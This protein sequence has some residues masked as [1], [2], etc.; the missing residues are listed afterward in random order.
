MCCFFI[1]IILFLVSFFFM[2]ATIFTNTLNTCCS[3]HSRFQASSEPKTKKR[4]S[5]NYVDICTTL[6]LWNCL[7]CQNAETDGSSGSNNIDKHV[8][9]PG[10]WAKIGKWKCVCW[11]IPLENFLSMLLHMHSCVQRA[12]SQMTFT[13]KR[14]IEELAW[15][16]QDFIRFSAGCQH[17]ELSGAEWCSKAVREYD[18]ALQGWGERQQEN[19]IP[20][21]KSREHR[22]QASRRWCHTRGA[23]IDEIHSVSLASCSFLAPRFG[24]LLAMSILGTDSY[25]LSSHHSGR[26]FIGPSDFLIKLFIN[27]HKN[28]RYIVR[29]SYES[30]LTL[31]SSH[32]RLNH[33][34][35]HSDSAWLHHA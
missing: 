6:L 9:A 24:D 2:R 20:R 21:W 30:F 27:M 14:Y 15:N 10:Y 23:W 16:D 35:C 11:E 17:S 18:W 28:R 26:E 29:E 4:A 19:H 22:S 8:I 13:M 7:E 1:I 3:Y 12:V 32:T 5:W 31:I 34:S 25:P 33:P